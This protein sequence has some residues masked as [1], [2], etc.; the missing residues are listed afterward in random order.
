MVRRVARCRHRPEQPD[1]FDL[2]PAREGPVG[3]LQ[4]R[5]LRREEPRT[6]AASSVCPIRSRHENACRR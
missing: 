2:V 3:Q 5:T 1:E 6:L 4:F